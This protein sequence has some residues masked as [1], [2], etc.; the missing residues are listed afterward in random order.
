MGLENISVII[1]MSIIIVEKV[2]N[3]LK[4][5]GI[6]FFEMNQKLTKIYEKMEKAEKEIEEIKSKNIYIKNGIVED[7]KEIRSVCYQML[8]ELKKYYDEE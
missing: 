2:L 4:S 3:I 5:R 7:I 6:D 1:F 8:V